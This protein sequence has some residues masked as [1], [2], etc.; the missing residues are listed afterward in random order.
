MENVITIPAFGDNLIYLYPYVGGDCLAVDPGGGA[1]VL[2]ALEQHNLTLKTILI[3]HH[4]GDHTGGI[5]DLKRKTGCRVIGADDRRIRGIDKLVA[6]GQSV[7]VG[8][9]E[10]QVI[11]TPGH[12][13]TSVCYYMPPSQ[14]G[15]SGILWTG[16]TMFVGGCGRLFESDAQTMWN[17]LQRLASLPDDTLV[18]CGH[19]YTVENYEFALSIEPDNTAAEQRLREIQQ[20]G[21]TVPSTMLQERTT[22]IFLRAGTTEVKAALDMPQAKDYEVFAELRQR[23]DIF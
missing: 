10:I 12:T 8:D 4:H 20:T 6:D 2:R 11:A 3:T 18:Y 22:S 15:T 23:K 14:S 19:D 16:D 21:R 13:S 5:G 9:A 7:H 1:P 17:S